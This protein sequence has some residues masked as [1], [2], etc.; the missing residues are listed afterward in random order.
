M[1][2]VT[3]ICFLPF[4]WYEEIGSAAHAVHHKWFGDTNDMI[5]SL[6]FFKGMAPC[7]VDG[8]GYDK[9]GGFV[10]TGW[11]DMGHIQFSFHSFGCTTENSAQIAFYI[12]Q[13]ICGCKG[14]KE[15]QIAPEPGTCQGRVQ[16]SPGRS[17]PVTH[18]NG[19]ETITMIRSLSPPACN[20]LPNRI[21]ANGTSLYFLT[22]RPCGNG[23]FDAAS[24]QV[25]KFAK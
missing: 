5:S 16:G 24:G 1:Y 11:I 12:G 9:N 14:R 6:I 22:V 19:F 13:Y 15:N 18:A 23:V 2:F 4:S 10:S 17:S 25:G 7:S 3:R 20:L 21:K 8:G